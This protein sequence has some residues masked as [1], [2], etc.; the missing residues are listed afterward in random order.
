MRLGRFGAKPEVTA[1]LLD[2]CKEL[3]ALPKAQRREAMLSLSRATQEAI[4]AFDYEWLLYGRPE[5]LAPAP[6]WR[7]W[8]MCGGRAGGKTRSAVEE[9]IEWAYDNPGIRIAIVGKDAGGVRKIQIS[10]KSGILRRSPPWFKARWYKTDKLIAFPNDTIV[11][12]HS[13]EE[14]T[15]L[16]GPEYHNA[17]I[18]ELFHWAIPKGEK[19]P[20]A[21]REGIKLGLRLGQNPQGIIDSSP[22][23]TQFCAD[24]L[25]GPEDNVGQRP[26]TQEMIESGEWKIEHSITDHEGVEHRYVN[27]VRRWSSE[28]NAENIAPGLIAEWRHDLRGSQ[29]EEQELD[30]KILVKV[31]GVLWTTEQLDAGRVDGVP[32][33]VKILVAVDPTRSNTPRD[34]AGIIVGALGENGH[35]YIFDDWS[36]HGSPHKWGRQAIDALNRF[37]ADAI[38]RESNRLD[39]GLKDLIRTIDPKVKWVDVHATEGKKTRAEPVSAAYE[40]GKVHHV[41]G[42]SLRPDRLSSDKSA[43]LE[44]AK[45]ALLED[46]MVTYDPRVQGAVSPNRMDALVW[47]VTALL[48]L[49]GQPKQELRLL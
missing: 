17:W 44:N 30:G 46:E 21:W 31:K 4:A 43:L 47:L 27:V 13:S 26:V 19:E 10:G 34:E 20:I 40:Q 45:F 16:R 35:V 25:L 29:L 5:Q 41:R 7:W 49:G 11:E 48:G 28:R 9:I 32:R 2:L 15:T 18:T 14:P 36:L 3:L 12:H 23:R 8:V 6:P 24:F 38:V 37:R 33:L 22:R 39:Q 1:A 42:E